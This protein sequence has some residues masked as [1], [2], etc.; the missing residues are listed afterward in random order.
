RKLVKK[1]AKAVA[2][3]ASTELLAFDP[4]Y[5]FKELNENDLIPFFTVYVKAIVSHKLSIGAF[6]ATSGRLYGFVLCY[7]SDVPLHRDVIDCLNP[8]KL[9]QILTIGDQVKVVGEGSE[10][11]DLAASSLIIEL[12]VSER[13]LS[14]TPINRELCSRIHEKAKN[15]GKV[16]LSVATAA[17]SQAI[18]RRSN[19]KRLNVIK[20]SDYADKKGYRPFKD[21]PEPNKKIEF[22]L[23]SDTRRLSSSTSDN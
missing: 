20:Y 21:I 9:N 13:C 22:W 3:L 8:A 23:L 2:K 11:A 15:I 18:L 19:G 10:Y 5:R 16:V 4:L 6:D 7:Y 1:D 14:D 12:A 17:D